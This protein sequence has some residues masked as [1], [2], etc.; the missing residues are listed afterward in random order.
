MQALGKMLICSLMLLGTAFVPAFAHH[1]ADSHPAT[2]LRDG[3][4]DFDFNVGVWHTHIRRLQHPLSGASDWVELHGTVTVQTIWNGKAQVE[5]IEAD[6]PAGRFEG[7]TLFLYNPAAHQW[8]QYFSSSGQGTLDTPSVGEFKNGRGEFYDQESYQGRTILVRGLWSDITPDT[9]RFEQA[10]SDD[11]GK[12]WEANFVADLT[13]T[14]PGEPVTEAKPLGDEPGQ[15]DFDWQ[16]GSWDIR[17]KRLERPLTGADAWTRLDGTVHVRK[18]WNGRANL[19]VIDTKGPSGH[20]EFLS[21]RLF[22]PE[23]RQWSLNFVSSNSGVMS[24]P[25]IGEFAHGRG[26]FY[27][28]EPFKGKSI[29]VRFSFLNIGQAS[30]R[31]EQAFSTD[32]GKTWETNWIN[33]STRRSQ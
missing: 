23:T 32:G 33:E 31:D 20:L 25:M 29:L 7:M 4:H 6:G 3:Q 15:H 11:G 24:T 21:L 12:T 30:N 5:E 28:Q 17:M 19:A 14:K 8:A 2:S 16:L 22:N 9:H 10:Y 13:R 18:L 27:D 1:A 26:D